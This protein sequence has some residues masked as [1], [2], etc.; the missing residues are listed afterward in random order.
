MIQGVSREIAGIV[1]RQAL[2]IGQKD[3]QVGQ[4]TSTTAVWW[5]Q[6]IPEKKVT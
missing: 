5:S 3:L 1:V 4:R 6:Y 2:P